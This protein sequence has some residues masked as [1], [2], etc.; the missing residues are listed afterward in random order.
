MLSDITART[1]SINLNSFIP[2]TKQCPA[3]FST[4]LGI[5]PVLKKKKLR[6]VVF[7]LLIYMFLPVAALLT[8]E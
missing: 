1:P 6:E 3:F 4:I 5:Y 2:L 8:D 7:W